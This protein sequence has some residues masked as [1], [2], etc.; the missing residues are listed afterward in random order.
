MLRYNVSQSQSP[1]VHYSTQLVQLIVEKGSA[2]IGP[3]FLIEI[4]IIRQLQP[5][6]ASDRNIRSELQWFFS[7]ALQI[8]RDFGREIRPNMRLFLPTS[9]ACLPI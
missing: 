7:E 3:A 1:L 6:W 4:H 9:D 5:Q 8:E 2:Q